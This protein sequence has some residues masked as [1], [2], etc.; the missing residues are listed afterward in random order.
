MKQYTSIVL[1]ML[2]VTY[3]A[4]EGSMTLPSRRKYYHGNP[5]TG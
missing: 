4:H 5:L 3:G 1:L 2:L